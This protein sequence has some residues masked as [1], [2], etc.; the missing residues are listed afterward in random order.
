MKRILLIACGLAAPL[1]AMGQGTMEFGLFLA[2]NSGNKQPGVSVNVAEEKSGN[3]I[4]GATYQAAVF[5]ANVGASGANVYS[6]AGA[7]FDGGTAWQPGLK[8][9]N[10]AF[11]NFNAAGAGAGYAKGSVIVTD[12]TVGHDVGST[13]EA[14]VRVWSSAMGSTWAT[15]YA[16]WLAH[17]QDPAYQIGVSA[18]QTVTLASAAGV[19]SRLGAAPDGTYALKS[20]SPGVV[21]FN[22]VES[23]PEPGV[24]ALAGL[25]M[26]GAFLIR[27]RK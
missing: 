11:L 1:L 3:K 10:T 8:L 20:S 18:V 6:S 23:V 27:R 15:A 25:G 7:V 13:T 4:T 16:S 5:F 2:A 9:G 22:V 19:Q 12:P 21:A 24:V 26:L 17:P 14:Q